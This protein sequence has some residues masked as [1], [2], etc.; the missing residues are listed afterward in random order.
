L[1]KR[2]SEVAPPTRLAYLSPI[3]FLPDQQPYKH[4]TTIDI[5][6]TGDR[7]NVIM[8]VDPLHDET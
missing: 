8:T 3:D 4:L 7:T 1:R 2:S 5:E 6:P